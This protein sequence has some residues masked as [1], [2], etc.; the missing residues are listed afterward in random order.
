MKRRFYASLAAYAALG[1][2]AAFTLRGD[3]RL[4]TLVFLGG[5]AIKT[6]IRYLAE[7]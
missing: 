1:A 3:I 7:F 2:L 6:Y 5:L 4:A